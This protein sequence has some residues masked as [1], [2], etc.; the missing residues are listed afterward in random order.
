MIDALVAVAF[1]ILPFV[2]WPVA[3]LLLRLSLQRPKIRSLAERAFLAFLIAIVTTVYALIVLNTQLGY[4]VMTR[5]TS[6]DIVRLFIFIVGLYPL[7]WLWAYWTDRFR[8]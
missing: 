7:W 2:N 5:D 3:V 1:L 4:P 8:D 6:R